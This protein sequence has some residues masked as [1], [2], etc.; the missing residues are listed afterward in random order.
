M[1]KK[2]ICFISYLD[3]DNL[4]VGYIAST[5]LK[6][7][8]FDILL[9]DIKETYPI[10]IENILEAEPLIVGFSI[11]FQAQLD[12]FNKLIKVLR[13]NKIQCHFTAGGHYPSLRYEELM[14]LIPE[15]D[16]VVLFE[17]EHTMTELA[18]KIRNNHEWK[19]IKGIA[20]RDKGRVKRNS[21]RPLEPDLDWFP[22]PVRRLFKPMLLG[23]KAV[24]LLAGRGCYYKCS[25]CSIQRFYAQPPG[26]V[27]RIRRPEFVAREMQLHFE[28]EGCTIFLFQDDD[29]PL[30]ASNGQN[31]I[32]EFC[33]QLEKKNLADKIM[34][35]ISCRVNEVDES[36]FSTLIDR[37][38]V[39]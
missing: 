39:V 27:K 26:K 2:K 28:Q 6:T 35:K 4:G 37:K 38:S 5:L 9:I 25:F 11:V 19:N 24:N 7:N 10:I 15:L 23:Q 12:I 30:S 20:Y 32:A 14:N 31:W 34:W 3:Q 22:L 21:L 1:Q 29:F 8:N 33:N 18:E 16:S 13:E 17:G 36:K